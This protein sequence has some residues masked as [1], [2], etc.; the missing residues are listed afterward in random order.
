M[1]EPIQRIKTFLNSIKSITGVENVVLTQRDGQPIESSGVWLSKNEIFGVCSIVSAVFNVAEQLH[2]NRLN[3]MLIDGE[4]AK[5]LI[6]PINLGLGNDRKFCVQNKSEYFLTVTA[7]I[8]VNL[9]AIMISMRD[10]LLKIAKTINDSGENFKPPLR[11][12]DE[13]ELKRIL[14]S[15]NLKDDDDMMEN[16]DLSNINID[17]QLSNKIRDCIFD[18][19]RNVPGVKLASIALNGGYP[20][21]NVS[22]DM[23]DIEAEGA[24]SYSLYDTS[25]R[26]INT[27]K[28]TPINNVL[29]ECIDYS[30]FI[31]GIKYG[32]FS[33]YI[34]STQKRLG[35]LRLLIPQYVNLLSD[36]M[37]TAKKVETPI[38]EVKDIFN[39]LLE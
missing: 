6:A 35:L 30:H 2:G 32:I 31:Y 21:L 23:K 8:R 25:K 13:N 22:L 16:V 36:Y 7:R 15:F 5:I 14:A 26:I 38:L 24:L 9:G 12:Y 27:L 4:R 37:K 1:D 28:K 20:L 33:T 29:C 39:N 18:F 3:Y 11:S 34:S 17:E 19:Y 10:T